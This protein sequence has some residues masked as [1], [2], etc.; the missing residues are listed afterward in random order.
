ML[1]NTDSFWKMALKYRCLLMGIAKKGAKKGSKEEPVPVSKD[2]R[3]AGP[4][5]SASGIAWRSGC[6]DAAIT[7]VGALI[8]N[9]RTVDQVAAIGAIKP[10][11]MLCLHS[12]AWRSMPCLWAGG[13]AGG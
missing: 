7:A 12:T 8:Q 10:L 9:P 3:M 2:P 5:V 11:C 1:S 4:I 13:R 6:G